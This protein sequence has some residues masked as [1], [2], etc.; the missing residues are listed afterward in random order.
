M[1]CS[2]CTIIKRVELP[3]SKREANVEARKTCI[4]LFGQ[5]GPPNLVATLLKMTGCQYGK[6]SWTHSVTWEE[7]FLGEIGFCLQ[8]SLEK[9]PTSPYCQS[10]LQFLLYINETA[11][12]LQNIELTY[13]VNSVV[14]CCEFC[15]QCVKTHLGACC[16][17]HLD[18]SGWSERWAASA[19]PAK[20]TICKW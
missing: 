2:L 12:M 5:W 4:L 10:G 20:S 13:A 7:C 11:P 19:S 3:G 17:L 9:N 8:Y 14:K 6:E 1:T 16:W 15:R 18:S